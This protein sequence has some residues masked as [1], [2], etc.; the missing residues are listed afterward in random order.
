MKIEELLAWAVEQGASDIFATAGKLPRLRVNTG[1]LV[2]DGCDPMS[3]EEICSFRRSVLG[4]RREADY[5]RNGSADAPHEQSEMRF[6][7]NFFDTFGGPA[8][9]VRSIKTGNECTFDKY[10]LPADVFTQLGELKRGIVLVTGSTGS[11]KSTTL[12]ALINYINSTRSCH[13]LTLE[14]PIEYIHNDNMSYISQRDVSGVEGGFE[15]AL[16]HALREN[17][18]VIVIGELR[19][20][21]TV[22]TAISAALTGHLVLATVHTL[23]A[24]S[25]VER[26]INMFPE[27]KQ[28]QVAGSVAI[29]LEAVVSQR[30]LPT[31][32][33]SGMVPAFEILLG[34][35]AVRKY[36]SRQEY[37]EL[38]RC[39][40]AYA[41]LGMRSFND[42]L[43]ELARRNMV[44]WDVAMQY[45]DNPDELKL[46][47]SGITSGK[48]QSTESIYS[49]EAAKSGQVD[50]HDI[51]RAAVRANASDILITGGIPPQLKVAGTFA[52][53]DLPPLDGNDAEHLIHSLLNRRQKVQLEEK[54]DIDL[55]ISVKIPSASMFKE[56]EMRRFRINIF[57]QRGQLALV[58]RLVSEQIPSPEELGLPA[59][60]KE[61]VQRK[62]GLFLVTGPT[63]SGK[64]TTLASLIQFI[65]N[66]SP[67]H[68]ISIE[69]PIEYV[70]TNNCCLIEQREIG[71]DAVDF[72]SGLRSAMRQAP[73]IIMVGEMRDQETISAALSA[74]ETGHLVM[75]T[76][77]SNNA[78]QTIERII[79]TF[80]EG[81]QNQIRQQFAGSV[82]GVVSQR[83]I[84]R[85]DK[86]GERIAAFE[87][88]TGSLAVRAIIRDKK[89]HQLVSV[90]E[91][92]QKDGMLTMTHSLD[93]LV[94][95]G[96]IDACD[97][98]NYNTGT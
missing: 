71:K 3:D 25:T 87:V 4:E 22:S 26:I 85:R 33:N 88:M 90:M 47:H 74:A 32:E 27:I 11:G 46:M 64:S 1:L 97:A 62:Q 44:T 60:L 81:Q 53:L 43:Y 19:D 91:S 73:D 48:T 72:H 95:K 35:A 37:G 41:H 17:P 92:S 5:S 7:I 24:I 18:D 89:T 69:D 70:F 15:S 84:P 77:H 66:S 83:L 82:L 63:G 29:A 31:A 52:P 38:E 14:D 28:E 78:M 49:A 98:K 55:A 61:L 39:L 40:R 65:N 10:S 96:I 45:S 80:P 6:R 57:H 75:G 56:K 36:I 68:I 93:E 23:D 16:R 76:L 13:I 12:S 79:D 67:R 2:I 51:F 58:A 50:M 86:A 94:K 54:R 59:I 42:S 34:T 9:V 8:M 20:T 21:E 30:L